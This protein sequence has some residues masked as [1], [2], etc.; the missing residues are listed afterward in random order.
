MPADLRI[1]TVNCVGV[2][3]AGVALAFKQ[4]YPAMFKAYKQ[5]CAAGLVKPGK[6]HVWRSNTEWIINFPTK[7]HWHDGSRYEDIE[8]GL[9][10]LAAYLKIHAP[11]RVTLPAL[12]CGNGGLNWSRVSEM[13]KKHLEPAAQLMEIFVFAP[14]GSA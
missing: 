9:E 6:M 10:A 3:G 11:L 4:R 7:R 14:G 13:I 12:G 1:N 5:D 2:M 8:V